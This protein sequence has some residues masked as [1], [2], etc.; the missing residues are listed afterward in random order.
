MIQNMIHNI[1]GINFYSKEYM[2]GLDV[3][4]QESKDA[5]LRKNKS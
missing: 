3:I 4:L 1:F 2:R 5:I